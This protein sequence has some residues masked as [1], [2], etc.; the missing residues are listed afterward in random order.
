M[1]ALTT[2]KHAGRMPLESEYL[3]ICTFTVGIAEQQVN[4]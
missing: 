1:Y 2:V 3:L 4:G